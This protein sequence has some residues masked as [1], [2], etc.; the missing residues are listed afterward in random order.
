MN[1]HIVCVVAEK[2]G[3]NKKI[4]PPD[5]HLQGH[6]FASPSVRCMLPRDVGK[7]LGVTRQMCRRTV[8]PANPMVNDDGSEMDGEAY[9]ETLV[10]HVSQDLIEGR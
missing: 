6:V 9:T 4:V 10:A 8:V 3:D 5:V 7:V 2:V 1:A